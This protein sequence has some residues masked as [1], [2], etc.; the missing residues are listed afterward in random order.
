MK[1]NYHTYKKSGVNIASADSLV[2]FI[3]KITK[4]SSI[5]GTNLKSFKNIG[6]F[7]SIYDLS[8]LNIKESNFFKI[9]FISIYYLLL[10]TTIVN[11]KDALKIS[12]KIK[13]FN[14]FISM[15]VSSLKVCI[16]LIPFYIFIYKFSGHSDVKALPFWVTT[17]VYTSVGGISWYLILMSIA[18]ALRF[19]RS[20]S[21]K[22]LFS[23]F[24]KK[25]HS[26]GPLIFTI[27][28]LKFAPTLT[29]SIMIKYGHKDVLMKFHIIFY[30]ESRIKIHLCNCK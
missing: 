1:K 19:N 29:K 22:E 30:S 7:G 16:P 8:K 12:G 23:S 3:S 13:C 17:L 9:G 4:K 6:S 27:I 21:Y 26:I 14:I 24:F 18:F 28:L 15:M 5:S 20:P 2:K 25:I 11:L 10:F